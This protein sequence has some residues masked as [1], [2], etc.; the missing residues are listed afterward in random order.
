MNYNKCIYCNQE[1]KEEEFSLE[2]IF[3]DALGGK[4]ANK[5]FK[6]RQVCKKCNSLAGLYVD[7]LFVKNF[8]L[9]KLFFSNY[10]G[11]FD[12][13]KKPFIPFTYIGLYEDIKH[14]QYKFCEVWQWYDKS[15]VYHFHNNSEGDF[16]MIP[17]GDPR[18]RKKNDSGEVYLVGFVVD[19]FWIDLLFS[20]FFKQFKK[21]KHIFVNYVFSDKEIDLTK[22]QID[23]KDELFLIH[24]KGKSPQYSVP[25]KIDFDVRFQAKLSLALGYSLFGEKFN[26]SSEANSLRDVFWNKDYQKLKKLKPQMLSFFKRGNSLSIEFI[27]FINF[28][29]CHGLFFIIVDNSL[30]FYANLFGMGIFPIVTVITTELDKYEHPL[31]EK[32]SRGWGYILAPQRELCIGDFDIGKLVAFNTGDK[33]FLPE[34]EKLEKKYISKEKLPEFE[35]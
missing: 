5:L 15:V 22:N 30:I 11:Y 23:I 7:S 20:S 4:Y 16:K 34:L 29:G 13:N 25:M 19:E 17:G 3:P 28:N 31:K 8:F 26:E 6:T 21:S 14:P 10:I 33:S 35:R 27:K 32:Y 9:T 24:E 2:H 1:K 18:K 12:F